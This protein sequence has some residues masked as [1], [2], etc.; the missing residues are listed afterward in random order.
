MFDWFGALRAWQKV[1]I[2]VLGLIVVGAIIGGITGDGGNGVSDSQRRAD[3]DTAEKAKDEE[4]RRAG[5]HCLDP[6]DRNHNGL[7]G[8]IRNQLHDPGSME[9]QDTLIGP[10]QE[11]GTHYIELE[12]TAKNALGG[13]VRSTAYGSVDNAT[14]AAELDGIF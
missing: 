7:E 13:R 3:E 2:V 8:L 6:W 1:L 11:D 5:L 14:C 10:V 9:T 4:Y 12:F